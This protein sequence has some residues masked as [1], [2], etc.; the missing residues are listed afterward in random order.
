MSLGEIYFFISDNYQL[1]NQNDFAF[2]SNV[3]DILN[4][5][6]IEQFALTFR[7]YAVPIFLR[8]E[9][10]SK[11]ENILLDRIITGQIIIGSESLYKLLCFC[12]HN[13]ELDFKVKVLIS[14]LME[15][16]AL[17][18]F[19]YVDLKLETLTKNN[20]YFSAR[21]FKICIKSYNLIEMCTRDD[22]TFEEKIEIL[23]FLYLP[24]NHHLNKINIFLY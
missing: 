15:N 16:Y 19:F 23:E 18:D 14:K 12:D 8:N 21:V 11:A 9:P 7:T 13:P 4:Q 22:L 24:S 5:K 6:P 20:I 1:S 17:N 2:V 10:K 3:L